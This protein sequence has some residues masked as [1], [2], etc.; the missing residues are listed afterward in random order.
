MVRHG[1]LDEMRCGPGVRECAVGSPLELDPS[2]L[3][4]DAELAAGHRESVEALAPINGDAGASELV[5]NRRSNRRLC[6][7]QIAPSSREAT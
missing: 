1:R 7:T 5:G 2:F 4:S 6:A 3:A